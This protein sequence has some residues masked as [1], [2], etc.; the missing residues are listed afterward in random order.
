MI[1]HPVNPGRSLEPDNDRQKAN[2]VKGWLFEL[3]QVVF[4]FVLKF[5]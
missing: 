5:G 1:L 2:P 4:V 3:V